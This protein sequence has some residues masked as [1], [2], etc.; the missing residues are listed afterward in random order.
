MQAQLL[1]GPGATPAKLVEAAEIFQGLGLHEQAG[2]CLEA[3]QHFLQAADC[4]MQAGQPDTALHACQKVWA[5][6]CILWTCHM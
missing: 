5:C 4:F 2:N 1:R 3:A 6:L